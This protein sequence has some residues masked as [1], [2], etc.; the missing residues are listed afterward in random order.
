MMWISLYCGQVDQKLA[1]SIVRQES[2]FKNVAPN[3]S[4][5]LMQILPSTAKAIGCEAKT[6][7]ELLNEELNVKCGCLYLQKLHQK[8]KKIN[9]VIASYNAGAV[10]ICKKGLNCKIGHYTNQSYVDSVN[11]WR[12]HELCYL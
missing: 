12:K 10:Y 3:A 8:Y 2:N 4:V 7:K 6:R 9:D 11:K 5:G 1:L